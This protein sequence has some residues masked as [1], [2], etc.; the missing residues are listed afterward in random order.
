MPDESKV[1]TLSVEFVFPAEVGATMVALAGDFNGWS[2]DTHRLQRRDD[3]RFAIRIDLPTGRRYQYRYWIDDQEW[4]NDWFAD[5]Y[6]PNEYG[7][8]NSL[9]DLTASSPRMEA[10][11]T[12]G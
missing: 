10:T 1:S 8:N 6:V 3:G 9:I 7:G 12:Q 4:E 5:A 2:T 11:E